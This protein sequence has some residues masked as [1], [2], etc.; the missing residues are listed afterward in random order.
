MYTRL[1]TPCSIRERNTFVVVLALDRETLIYVV[2]TLYAIYIYI[3]IVI[4]TIVS[5]NIL[6]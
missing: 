6:E 5:D 1:C 2:Y 3:Y 4:Y